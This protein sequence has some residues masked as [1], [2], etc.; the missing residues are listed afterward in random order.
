[1]KFK[2]IVLF[3]TILL[4]GCNAAPVPEGEGVPA[5]EDN[6]STTSPA[7]DREETV[8]QSGA[9]DHYQTV[10]PYEI[11][12]SRG[13]TSTNMVSSY[14]IEAF[15]KGLFDISKNVFPTDEYV[16][17]EG[18]IFTEDMVRGF[19]DR[20]YT[21]EEIE[22]MSE[23][24]LADSNAFSNLGLNPSTEGEEDP[25]VIAEEAPL[26][27]SHILEQNYLLRDEEGDMTL[28]GITIGLAM[29]STHYYQ[30][31]EY[32]TTYSRSLDEDE[33]HEQGQAMANEIL[34]RLRANERYSDQTIT[35][36][37]FIQSDG[38][39]I[40]PGNF[41]SYAVAE[42]GE[43]ELSSFTEVNEDYVLFPSS[44]AA[45]F[46]E[47]IN[48]DYEVFNR[49]LGAYFDSF[50]TS[51]GY[52]R[53]IDGSLQTLSIEIPVE[54]T[55]HGEII[56]LAQY[57]QNLLGDH[58]SGSAVEVSI[59]DKSETYALITKNESD[60]ITTHIYE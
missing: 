10:I 18:Q 50:T 8:T 41:V 4:A 17:R 3:M 9:T 45:E 39:A 59:A 20:R 25:E 29:N 21:R 32:G 52:G 38:T 40:T 36:A 6:V 44:E 57:V 16:F 37:I 42:G 15:E 47:Q 56:G 48:N 54:Y 22:D 46:N 12:P 31:E 14:N 19:L 33:V 11:S 60:E 53:F 49:N 2:A 55:S 58:F 13:L 26:Y 51:V 1:M 5:D 34:D 30:T 28:D 24:E 35:F 23:E 43:D 7:A 27:L